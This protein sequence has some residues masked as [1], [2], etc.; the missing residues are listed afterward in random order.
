MNQLKKTVSTRFIEDEAKFSGGYSKNIISTLSQAYA[1]YKLKC[2]LLLAIGF[3]GRVLLMSNANIVGLWVDS[4]C[5][6]PQI[7]TPLPRWTES[8]DSANFIF[9]LSAVSLSGL[10]LTLLF[11]IWFSRLSSHA[12]SQFYDEVTL[13]TSRLPISF[14]DV[15]PVGRVVTRFSSDYGNVFRLFGGPL[16][17]FLGIIF[18]I[19]AM[20]VLVTFASR[21]YFLICIL[22][23]GLNYFVYRMNRANLRKQR[24]GLSRNRSPSISHFAETAQGATTIRTFQKQS[25]FFKRFTSLNLLFLN[26]RLKT[27]FHLLIFSFQMNAL[28]ALLLLITGFNAYFFVKSGVL[29]VGSVG[30]AF[31][32]IAISGNTL[33]MFFDWISQFEEALI[34]VERL[35]QYLRYP[36]ESGTKLPSSAQFQASQAKYT[37]Q[38][39]DDLN[40]NQL[41]N[42]NSATIEIQNLNFRYRQDLPQVLKNISFSVAAGE[43]LGIIGRTGSGKTSLIQI[44]FHLYPIE[45]GVIKID[46]HEANLQKNNFLNEKPLID[47]E[48]YRK[49]MALISQD[50]TI[51]KGT[52]R[53]NL[54]LD[55]SKPIAELIE[56]LNRVGLKT[57]FQFLP[58]GLNTTIEERGRNL[59]QGEKQL[60]CMARCL[61]QNCPIVIMD[62][63]TSNV[64]PHSEE[65]LVRAT[66][67]FFA[68]KTQIIVAH[69]L[70]T[71]ENCDRILWLHEGEIKMLGKPQE[72]LK[73]FREATF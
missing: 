66:N 55:C 26:Q 12:I 15:T 11:R 50:P 62:E 22:I 73:A 48:L 30:V 53:E 33:Q 8:L 23:A 25:S 42:K 7:C 49:S 36:I 56:T 3:L 71:I 59:S 64:D 46:G 39:E 67:D 27:T 51:F 44:L 70:S 57:W 10:C 69:R 40:K 13:R 43:R 1:P 61:L 72:V 54:S 58:L 14:F 47:L 32:F 17:E 63:A 31:S 29:S 45:S 16:A 21:I 41:F 5:K 2:L 52:L 60:I 28:T 65:I 34:G 37:Y 35:D 24:R 6:S 19:L 9:L 20:I 18:D 4:M 38:E 68:D